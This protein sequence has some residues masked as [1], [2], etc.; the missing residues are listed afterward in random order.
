MNLATL[1]WDDPLL[2]ELD[3]PRAVLPKIVPSSRIYGTVGVPELE[4]APL[5][6]ILGDQQAALVG[7]AC[8][9]P[10]EAKNTYGTGCFLLQHVGASPSRSTRGLLATAAYTLG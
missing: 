10:G 9:A 7:Q 4:G 3:V 8:F 1:E 5:A 2:R 6:G